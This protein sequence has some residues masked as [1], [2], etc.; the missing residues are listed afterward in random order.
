MQASAN[1]F[2]NLL[3]AF[4]A[5]V[6][7]WVWVK[8]L[9]EQGMIFSFVRIKLPEWLSKPLFEC[10]YCCAGQLAFWGYIFTRTKINIDNFT[11]ICHYFSFKINIPIFDYNIIYHIITICLTLLMVHI[12]NAIKNY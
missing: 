10:E 7:G 6:V 2:N 8:I 3:I 4:Y 11:F 1:L 9:T 12:F 5:A